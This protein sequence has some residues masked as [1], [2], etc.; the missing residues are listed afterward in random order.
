MSQ[1][2][3][4][5]Y[6][7]CSVR[8][9]P[10][11]ICHLHLKKHIGYTEQ[12]QKHLQNLF[13]RCFCSWIKFEVQGQ[14]IVLL[15][16]ESLIFLYL[17]NEQTNLIPSYL[18]LFLSYN[19]HFSLYIAF[20][21]VKQ[22][23]LC[24]KVVNLRRRCVASKWKVKI[25]TQQMHTQQREEILLVNVSLKRQ[26]CYYKNK[27]SLCLLEELERRS[28]KQTL[29]QSDHLVWRRVSLWSH[30]AL[31]LLSSLVVIAPS[32]SCRGLKDTHTHTHTT[33]SA[34][35]G[36]VDARLQILTKRNSSW[37]HWLMTQGDTRWGSDE[38]NQQRCRL[39]MRCIQVLSLDCI[40]RQQGAG[41][42]S[43]HDY[44]TLI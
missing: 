14:T 16:T 4:I 32:S 27:Y 21:L 34:R 19:R 23:L 44:I 26:K 2:S 41:P 33:M 5:Q 42:H 1:L 13:C 10:L 12:L 11:H 29:D 38:W 22:W 30:S 24:T 17:N 3:C 37:T 15:F 7:K 25:T 36:K 31:T 8:V 9:H 40:R 39:L 35:F 18:L 43:L 28:N 20:S 6:A